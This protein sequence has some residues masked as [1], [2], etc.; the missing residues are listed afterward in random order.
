MP[1]PPEQST[2]PI[3]ELFSQRSKIL[4]TKLGI[5]SAQVIERLTIRANNLNSLIEEESELSNRILNREHR[6]ASSH[7]LD[8]L[9]QQKHFILQ[10]KR[11]QDVECWRDLS[12]TLRDLLRTWE[13]L[14]QSKV[15]DQLLDAGQETE[16]ANVDPEYLQTSEIARYYN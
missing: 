12:H 3:S 5:L 1:H 2:D 15:R 10:E 9:R 11:S 6:D 13:E 4:Q 8:N 16:G 7:N 14:E